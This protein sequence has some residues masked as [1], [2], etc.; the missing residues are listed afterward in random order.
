MALG[1]LKVKN[2]INPPRPIRKKK[3][4]K[5]MKTK[6]NKTHYYESSSERQDWNKFKTLQL[7]ESSSS[8]EPRQSFSLFAT[9]LT[10]FYAN[11]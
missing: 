4:R 2:Y 1:S 5:E 7:S 11:I 6:Q 3:K 8:F 9:L 10:L